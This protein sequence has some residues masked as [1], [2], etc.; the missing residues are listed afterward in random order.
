MTL[1]DLYLYDMTDNVL[2]L[3]K[4]ALEKYPLMKKLRQKVGDDPKIKAYLSKRK[5]T[6]F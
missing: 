2:A 4:D 3:K 5:P 1:A 6:K